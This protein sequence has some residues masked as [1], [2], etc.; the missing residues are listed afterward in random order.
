M[1]LMELNHEAKGDLHLKA[2]PINIILLTVD[3]LAVCNVK[4]V[5]HSDKLIENYHLTLLCPSAL[6]PILALCSSL[7]WF[8]CPQ[9]Y[10][11]GSVSVL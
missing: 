7:F 8:Y 4:A 10:C 6:S 9:L 1:M 5:A 11:Y 3:Q 2:A